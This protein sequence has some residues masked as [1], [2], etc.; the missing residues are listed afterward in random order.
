VKWITLL[1]I[2]DY[3]L[4]LPNLARRIVLIIRVSYKLPPINHRKLWYLMVPSCMGLIKNSPWHGVIRSLFMKRIRCLISLALV[5]VVK[6]VLTIWT[7]PLCQLLW[8]RGR[9]LRLVI[10][11]WLLKNLSITLRIIKWVVAFSWFI[12]L[13]LFNWRYLIHLIWERFYKCIP[14]VSY[15]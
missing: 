14:N 13:L 10:L 7:S 12:L 6:E 4:M 9:I 15:W 8:L 11:S 5:S 3:Y 2:K 1:V